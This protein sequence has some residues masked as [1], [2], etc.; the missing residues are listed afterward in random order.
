V[1]KGNPAALLAGMR[2]A[3]ELYRE[4]PEAIERMRK[5]GRVRCET[6]FQ[7]DVSAKEYFA[8]YEKLLHNR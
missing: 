5:N 7:W 6:V 3:L 2:K 8:I 1:E 4:N